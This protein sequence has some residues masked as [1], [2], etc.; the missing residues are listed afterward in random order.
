MDD[1][2]RDSHRNRDFA[3]ADDAELVRLVARARDSQDPSDKN[4]GTA[5]WKTLVARELDR[6]LG[7]VVTFRFPGEP[8]V[9]VDPAD[10]DDATQ[11]ALERCLVPLLRSFHGTT[12]GEFRAALITCTRF[13]CMDFCRGQLRRERGLAGSLDEQVP[14]GEGDAVGRF[15]RDMAELGSRIEEARFDARLGL[16]AVAAAIESF[17]NENMRAVLRLTSEGYSSAEIAERLGLGVANVD[18]LRSRGYR[19]LEETLRNDDAD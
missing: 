12:P 7:L 18:Q 10:Y 15:D 2:A 5:A 4:A 16:E 13:A 14:T 6:V 19:R 3:R 1:Q 11:A 8:G 9:R 17:P